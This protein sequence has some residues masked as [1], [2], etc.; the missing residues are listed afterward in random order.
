MNP[1]LTVAGGAI[2]THFHFVP[3]RYHDALVSA[4]M[5]P[6]DNIPGLPSWDVD[7]TLE[8]MEAL[9][10]ATAFMSISSPGV[11]LP[12]RADT[13]ALARDCNDEGAAAVREH[14][15]RLGLFAALPLPHLDDSLEELGRASDELDADGVCLMSN[16][17]GR[18]VG[19]PEFYP[20]LEELNRRKTVVMLHPASPPNH[21]SVSFG[22]PTPI[23]EFPFETT[24]TVV[25]LIL[26]GAIARFPDIRWI[27]PHAGAT[28]PVLASRVAFVAELLSTQGAGIDVDA[29]LRSFHYDLA[30][31]PLPILLPAL[32]AL[33]GSDRLLYGSDTPFTPTPP[34][35]NLAAQLHG[36]ELFDDETRAAT[37]RGNAEALFPRLSL[38]T[39]AGRLT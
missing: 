31:A 6:P 11:W 23:I 35:V 38:A 14:P 8:I 37:F 20:L 7:A 10:V 34:A 29:A 28:L 4:D 32:I 2:D 15:T 26:T 5:Y 27:I 30:G 9:G 1:P 18:Y 12:T 33:V 13:V 25:D 3:K 24:R 17:D 21:E 19:D 16:Q 36:T 22:R 39:E